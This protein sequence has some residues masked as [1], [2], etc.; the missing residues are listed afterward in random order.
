MIPTCSPVIGALT[1]LFIASFPKLRSMLVNIKA[2]SEEPAPLQWMFDGIYAVGFIA[3]FLLGGLLDTL[4]EI[5]FAPV[6]LEFYFCLL[7]YL[8]VPS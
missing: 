6:L 4:L 3:R 1:G 7:L 8:F 2:G 5:L